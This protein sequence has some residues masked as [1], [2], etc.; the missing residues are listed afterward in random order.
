MQATKL[1][2]VVAHDSLIIIS[3]R[4]ALLQVM[5]MGRLLLLLLKKIMHSVDIS[6]HAQTEER[7]ICLLCFQLLEKMGRDSPSV[8]A[9]MNA[10]DM[11]FLLEQLQHDCGSEQFFRQVLSRWPSLHTKFSTHHIDCIFYMIRAERK[12]VAFKYLNLLSTLCVGQANEPIPTLQRYIGLKLIHETSKGSLVSYSW[13]REYVDE[14]R[15][16]TDQQ[17]VVV[18]LRKQAIWEQQRR[19]DMLIK[20]SSV[21]SIVV[22]I[23]K[24]QQSV[25]TWGCGML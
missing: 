1:T 25:V 6:D 10:H 12:I 15:S 4:T 16:S 7:E 17:S 20:V 18:I 8:L 13:A 14:L 5:K 21:P 3:R 2:P 22:C 11:M 19:Q 23:T 24:P 9:E